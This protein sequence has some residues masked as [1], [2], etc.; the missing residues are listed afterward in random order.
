LGGAICGAIGP[1]D[2]EFADSPHSA[3]LDAAM[4]QLRG[5]AEDR[6]NNLG[7]IGRGIE[8]RLGQ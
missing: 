3:L 1:E 7:K 4:F 5:D 6:K 2:R 8:E